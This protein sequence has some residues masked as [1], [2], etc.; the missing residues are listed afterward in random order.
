MHSMIFDGGA[1]V[2]L[3]EFVRENYAYFSFNFAFC[4]MDVVIVQGVQS[5]ERVYVQY[6]GGV[7]IG[8]FYLGDAMAPEKVF[9]I[10]CECPYSWNDLEKF[11]EEKKNKIRLRSMAKDNY[12]FTGENTARQMPTP[13][14]F[15]KNKF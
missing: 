10:F 13:K 3:R 9:K 2:M 15:D 5:H 4:N 11:G 6:R 1:E 7:K 12:V 14:L 8:Y